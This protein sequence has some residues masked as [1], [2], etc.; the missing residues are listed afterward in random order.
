M[1]NKSS[2]MLVLAL[3]TS[4]MIG[5]LPI[6]ATLSDIGT[7]FMKNPLW[8]SSLIV[9]AL[10]VYRLESKGP[11]DHISY[12]FGTLMRSNESYIAKL[13]KAVAWVDRYVIG[14]PYKSKSVKAKDGDLVISDP[15]EAL[16]FMGVMQSNIKPALVGLG[17]AYF[18][19]NMVDGCKS[20]DK[21]D[22]MGWAL[23]AVIIGLK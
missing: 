18:L 20:K 23:L 2:K 3:G 14:Q 4:F 12:D 22:T 1:V 17:A 10:M 7:N 16:G 19:N 9:P 13:K 15:Q 8:Y 11:C 5:S 6:Q 21:L